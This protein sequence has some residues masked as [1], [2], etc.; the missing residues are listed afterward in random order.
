MGHVFVPWLIAL[1]TAA[2]TGFV[3][4]GTA[5]L[6]FLWASSKGLAGSSATMDIALQWCL[7]LVGGLLLA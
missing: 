4:Y 3:A 7:N 5:N 1:L 2:L 6:V